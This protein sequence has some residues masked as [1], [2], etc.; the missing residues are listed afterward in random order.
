MPAS[1]CH[2]A[3]EHANAH[4]AD[5]PARTIPAI[6]S[7]VKAGK[8]NLRS[9]YCCWPL[10][11]KLAE[12]RQQQ[13]QQRGFSNPPPPSSP[14]LVRFVPLTLPAVASV[15][16]VPRSLLCLSSFLFLC[17]LFRVCIPSCFLCF[18]H[19]LLVFSGAF[20]PICVFMCLLFPLVSSSVTLSW[21]HIT[22]EMLRFTLRLPTLSFSPSLTCLS[23]L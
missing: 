19:S 1:L 9:T 23:T 14:P 21:P 10:T 2:C 15:S 4:K 16:P 22:V 7:F 3:Y 12:R 17:R 13:Q 6:W 11:L 8:S 18:Y 5:D 20:V